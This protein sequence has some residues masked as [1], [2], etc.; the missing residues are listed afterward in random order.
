[1]SETQEAKEAKHAVNWFEIPVSQIERAAKFYSDI[2]DIKMEKQEWQGVKMAFFPGGGKDTVHGALV[3]GEGYTP[4]DKGTLVYL[5][6][7]PDLSAALS[8][9]EKA[10][11]KVVKP[12]FAIGEHGFIAYF[13]DTEGNK[14]ALHSMQ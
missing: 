12:K 1:M 13:T 5:N 8:R 11:G 14:V 7:S 3:Q 10:G 2:F 4:S 9:V 6:G